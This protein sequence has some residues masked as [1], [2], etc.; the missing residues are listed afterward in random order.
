M[1]AKET[2]LLHKQQ[3]QRQMAKEE[4]EKYEIEEERE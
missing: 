1:Q 3:Q 4:Y 2:R